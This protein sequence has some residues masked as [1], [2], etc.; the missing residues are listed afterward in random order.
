MTDVGT[1]ERRVALITGSSRGV[2]RAIAL[3]LAEDGCDIAVNYRRDK[4]AADDAVAQIRSLGADAEAFGV[5]VAEPEDCQRLAADVIDRFGR[6]DILVCNAGIASRGK[7]VADTDPA[8][9]LRVMGVHTFGAFHLCAAL[10]P[11]LRRQPRSDVAFISSAAT[12]TN[13]A[14]GS[15][16]NMA[17]AAMESLAFTLAKEEQANGVRVNVVA[18]GL[19]VTEM[20]KRLAKAMGYDEIADLDQHMPF[21][22][23]CRPDDVAGTVRWLVSPHASYI[24]GQRI[25]VNGGR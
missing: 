7:S 20:G 12:L 10:L 15:P 23:V 21:G 1:G 25:Y 18:P 4:D 6:A 16:Y 19:V 5:S 17:K 24:S 8:E 22:R 9:P 13:A 14:N 11:H 3:A 2:G